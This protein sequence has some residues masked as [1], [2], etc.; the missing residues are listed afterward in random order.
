MSWDCHGLCNCEAWRYIGDTYRSSAFCML[1]CIVGWCECEFNFCRG[2]L[3]LLSAQRHTNCLPSR[4]GCSRGLWKSITMLGWPSPPSAAAGLECMPFVRWVRAEH[5]DAP[6]WLYQ[7]SVSPNIWF[8]KE[9]IQ[10]QNANVMKLLHASSCK[11]L[12][13]A[14]QCCTYYDDKVTKILA[15]ISNYALNQSKNAISTDSS[16]LW[17]LVK[18]VFN[19]IPGH[20]GGHCQLKPPFEKTW[21]RTVM[22]QCIYFSWLNLVM[23]S[24]ERYF[25]TVLHQ[26]A[27][28]VRYRYS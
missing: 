1:Q 20:T 28:W 5:W 15:E 27:Y 23:R 12:H 4:D 14:S 22:Y 9:S 8:Y 11:M 19:T 6:R 3:R 18:R 10:V 17:A 26:K 2:R 21:P 7:P 16:Y 24:L 25:D 13:F